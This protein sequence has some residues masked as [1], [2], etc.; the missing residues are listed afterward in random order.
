MLI[1]WGKLVSQG[2]AKAQGVSWTDEEM[3][4]LVLL[5]KTFGKRMSEMAG[6]VRQ[7]IL[8]VED[9]NK[10]QSN[11]GAVNPYLKLTKEDLMKKAQ[12]LDIPV[13]PDVTKEILADL[14]LE[15]KKKLAVEARAKQAVAK[16][17][18]KVEE[19]VA[20]KAK[21]EKPK[22]PAKKPATKPKAKPAKTGKA[23][24]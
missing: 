14:I 15:K 4:A 17:E 10:A 1:D 24:K 22:A 12:E 21:V 13:S 6:Y 18:P 7:G 5:C 19:K 3:Q 20:P 9:Y 23:K 16:P 8:T 2:R 11:P